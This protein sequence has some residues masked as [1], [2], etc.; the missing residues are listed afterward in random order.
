[1]T[2]TQVSLC[3]AVAL[4][5]ALLGLGG[6]ARADEGPQGRVQITTVTPARIDPADAEDI[7]TISG[8]FTNTT[9][10]PLAWASAELWHYTGRLSSFEEIDAAISAIDEAP[11]G[12]RH[13]P[14][15]ILT[16]QEPLAPGATAT[17]TIGAPVS[18][19][20]AEASEL[21]SIVG[22][23]VR[24]VPEG[25]SQRVTVARAR[26]LVPHGALPFELVDV[27]LL[28]AA[29]G[30]VPGSN[31]VSDELTA[32]I[33]GRLTEQLAA[34]A[35]ASTV[36]V[37]DPAIYRA[38]LQLADD[39]AGDE[40]AIAFVEAIDRLRMEGKL[41]RLPHGNP[42]L[43]R[44][45]E[46]LRAQVPVWADEVVVPGLEDVPSVAIVRDVAA[47]PQ[48]FDHVVTF[49]AGEGPTRFFHL[50]GDGRPTL[51]ADAPAPSA[52]VGLPLASD[53]WPVLDGQ[54]TVM[55]NRT[56]LRLD[57]TTEPGTEPGPDADT[58]AL[59]LAAYSSNLPDQETAV[60]YLTSSRV[61]AFDPSQI[62]L[63]VS[64]SFVMGSRTNQ[65]PA[66]ITNQTTLPVHL[67]IA[68]RSE[69]PQRIR[70][71][72][73]DVI[74]VGSGES[75]TLL[76]EPQAAANGVTTVHAQLQSPEGQRLGPT[77]AVE[78][79]ATE[80]GRVGWILIIVSGAVVLGGTVW[81]I[82][83]VRREQAKEASESGQ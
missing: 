37:I 16:E 35:P 60:G 78:I 69:N 5:L 41:W 64:P 82:R 57:L 6:P 43:A 28:T 45:P 29:P 72:D 4:T 59:T 15:T 76:L 79:T 24:A 22:V 10:L 19:I 11:V 44:M 39:G 21:A 73:T 18:A 52:P 14:G 7:V 34:S 9:G 33:A 66:T 31:A 54:V 17:F 68:L 81:R 26:A 71:P 1:M 46:S 30:Q 53:P 67:R 12:T 20:A 40:A 61:A 32:D 56:P 77:L 62:S 8:T 27:N 3:L 13:E 65:F 51:L 80:F 47:V 36:T 48:G 74:E 83:A 49:A 55:Q 63:T 23:H 50:L 58:R 70:V 38:A 2:R 75:M 42:N 25:T